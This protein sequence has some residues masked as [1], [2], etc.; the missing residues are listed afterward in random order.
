MTLC[1][2]E[3]SAEI[4][5]FSD[6]ESIDAMYTFFIIDS[7]GVILNRNDGLWQVGSMAPGYYRVFGMSHVSELI[8]STAAAGMG[9]SGVSSSGCIELSENYIEVYVYECQEQAPCSHLI[10]SEMIEH[11]QSNKALELYNPTPYPIQL[12]DYQVRLYANGSSAASFVQSLSG[13]LPAHNTLVI[14]APSTGSGS[15]DAALV[16]AT[17]LPSECATFT[18]NDAIELAFQGNA[19]DVIGLVGID[20]GGTG[21]LFGNSSTTNRTLV[22]R[23]DIVSPST[24]WS[25]SS[26]QWISYASNDYSHIGY[27]ESWNCGLN[28]A[29]LAGFE[30]STQT[31]IEENGAIISIPIQLE[32]VGESFPLEVSISG[33]ATAGEDYTLNSA[34]EINVEA[35]VQEVLLE[36]ALIG[37]EIWEG[38]ETI[39][40]SLES[41]ED[42]FFTQQTHTVI[43]QENVGVVEFEGEDIRIFPN[44]VVNEFTIQTSQRMQEAILMDTQG[45]IVGEKKLHGHRQETE[46]MVNSIQA[47]T[48]ILQLRIDNRFVHIPIIVTR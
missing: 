2:G 3:S 5:L 40:L 7:S 23:P 46:W 29:P 37:D 36:I 15:I 8:D 22:R 30:T 9:L 25:V 27:H 34:V 42:V 14:G 43:I 47:G 1:A 28:P 39:I 31:V 11:T 45:R 12:N 18:G 41:D 24:N 33:T 13:I 44:P 26:G 48:Y 10:I 19:I 16:S 32:S 17:D 4:P 21:W 38:D 20:P 35:G 6:S